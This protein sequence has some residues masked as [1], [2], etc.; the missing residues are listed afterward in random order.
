MRSYFA[1]PVTLGEVWAAVGLWMALGIVGDIFGRPA[2]MLL[3]G[4]ALLVCVASR[5]LAGAEPEPPAQ[6]AQTA[7]D[8]P[9]MNEKQ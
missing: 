2:A 1:R 8:A 7:D 5:W 4:V 9:G 3:A 6:A